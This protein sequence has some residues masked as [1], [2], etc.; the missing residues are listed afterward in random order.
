MQVNS[1]ISKYKT[2][3]MAIAMIWIGFNHAYVGFRFKPLNFLL[4]TC[5]YGGVDLFMFLSGFGLYFALK[6]ETKYLEFLKRRLIRI[7][8]YNIIVCLI[9]M[10]TYNRT[11]FETVVTGLGLNLLFYKS[12][13]GWYTSFMLFVY[14]LTPLYI[15]IFNKNPKLVT[16][17]GIVIVFSLCLLI[18]DYEFTYMFFRLTTYFLGFYFAYRYDNRLKVNEVIWI[19]LCI[20]GWP[21]MYY[22]YHYMGTGVQHVYPMI[23]ITPGLLIIL[24]HFFEKIKIFNK[25]LSFIGKYTY[26][27]YLLQSTTT[28]F[29]Y[30]FYGQLFFSVLIIGFDW[31]LNIVCSLIAFILAVLLTKFVEFIL[32]KDKKSMKTNIFL[33]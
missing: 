7:L 17:I 31:F 19:I 2:Q 1:L 26:Q 11:L 25:S 5:G 28:D 33:A 22:M 15:K 13:S 8:P 29:V 3:L 18:N 6:K 14:L 30:K 12:L 24:S 27:F 16:T 9:Q 32:N 21:F 20:L 4:V 23:F 10:F